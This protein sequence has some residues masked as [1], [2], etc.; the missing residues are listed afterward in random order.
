MTAGV[1]GVK[2]VP[3]RR[4][5]SEPLMTEVPHEPGWGALPSSPGHT[6]S[7]LWAQSQERVRVRAPPW[8][9]CVTLGRLL[10]LSVSSGGKLKR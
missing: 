2:S 5:F 1:N 6:G 4:D 10:N 7:V 8:T 9:R 3:L